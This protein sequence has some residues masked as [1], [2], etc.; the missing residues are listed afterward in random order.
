[1][2][3]FLS[4]KKIGSQFNIDENKLLGNGSYGRVYLCTDEHNNKYAVKCCD[5]DKNGIPNILETTIMNCLIHPCLNKAVLLQVTDKNLYIFQ[6]MAVMD[7]AKKT[8]LRVGQENNALAQKINW[9][10]AIANAVACLHTE[11]MIH[12]DI[13]A[14]NILL[15]SDD[16]VKLTDFTLTLK[17]W[18]SKE[19]FNHTVCTRTHR[20]LECLLKEEWD[21]SLDIWSLGCT[22]YEILYGRSLFSDQE[23]LKGFINAHIY[24]AQLHSEE[25]YKD[26]DFF[27]DDFIKPVLEKSSENILINDLLLKMLVVDKTKRLTI[28]EILEHEIFAACPD[29]E[30]YKQYK[31]LKRLQPQSFHNNIIKNNDNNIENIVNYIYNS[32]A[33]L[34]TIDDD[35]KLTAC[36]FIAQKLIR[37]EKNNVPS[38]GCEKYSKKEIIEAEIKICLFLNFRLLD[39]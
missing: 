4:V 9:M 32:C 6:E 10:Y 35:L 36:L 22:F 12:C 3:K 5:L 7:L 29:K 23:S 19:K 38:S 31:R 33:D 37:S 15:F 11:N 39:F 24:W 18:T 2:S 30:K 21:E 26:N 28:K 17:K 25:K 27:P 34:H 13:K 1:M 8:R 16:S 14:S 20:P